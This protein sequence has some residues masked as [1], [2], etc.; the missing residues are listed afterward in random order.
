MFLEAHTYT[1]KYQLHIFFF[2]KQSFIDIFQKQ[3]HI[4]QK[5]L[6]YT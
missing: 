1:K 2:Q 4:L 6:K 5:T 3:P